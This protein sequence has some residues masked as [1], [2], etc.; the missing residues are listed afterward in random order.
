MLLIRRAKRRG[1]RIRMVL[2]ALAADVLSRRVRGM[3]IRRR[4]IAVEHQRMSDAS[5]AGVRR[6]GPGIDVQKC[7]LVANFVRGDLW[8]LGQ[9]I[10]LECGRSAHQR[11]GR[12]AVGGCDRPHRP[13]V[14]SVLDRLGLSPTH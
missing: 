9:A 4:S 3:R 7:E 6:E 13:S 1:L 10:S 12:L 5:G 2:A 11:T 8:Q 14:A